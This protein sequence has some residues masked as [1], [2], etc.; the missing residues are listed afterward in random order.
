MGHIAI[1]S[2]CLS[3]TVA[4]ILPLTGCKEELTAS[5]RGTMAID[6][7]SSDWEGIPVISYEKEHATLRISN[8]DKNLYLLFETG[9]PRTARMI[10]MSG[11][12]LYLDNSGK[13]RK[14][15]FVRFK[16]G[17]SPAEMRGARGARDVDRTQPRAGWRDGSGPFETDFDTTTHF[18]C[19]EKNNI[20]EKEIPIDGGEGPAVAYSAD[21]DGFI[22]EFRI[23]LAKSS[24]RY[25]GIG[26]SAGQKIG[27]GLIWGD[28]SAFRPDFS[29]RG[30][31]GSG[32]PRIGGPS[33]GGRGRSTRGPGGRGGG[34]GFEKQEVWFKARLA[35][36]PD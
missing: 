33:A 25:Y 19:Y 3:A 22:Y 1:I 9:D 31:S 36:T 21:G 17:P 7:Q 23:P 32:S 18:T 14:D 10:R 28:R 20:I 6:G 27:V 8:D 34:P 5:H 12:T 16:G 24:I 13:R 15:F 2:F 11:I 30:F 35:P 26:T 29:G 4:L